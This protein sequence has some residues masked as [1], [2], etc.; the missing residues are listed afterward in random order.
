VRQLSIADDLFICTASDLRKRIW[1]RQ[2]IRT[3]A[4][5]EADVETT[6]TDENGSA[7]TVISRVLRLVV[8]LHN[9]EQVILLGI[10]AGLADYRPRA[11]LEWIATMLR[12]ALGTEAG[13]LAPPTAGNGPDDAIQASM[14]KSKMP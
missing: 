6:S 14:P 10:S 8:E 5:V 9:G 3:I 1:Y 7:H 2:E 12:Q 4:L 11:E 13:A